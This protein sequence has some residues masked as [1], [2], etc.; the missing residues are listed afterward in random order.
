MA[1]T[2]F[3]DEPLWTN[4]H[5]TVR[6]VPVAGRFELHNSAGGAT[7]AHMVESAAAIQA[8]I[9]RACRERR[10][11]RAQGAAWSFSEAAAVPGGW[12]LATGHANWLFRLPASHVL[13]DYPFDRDGLIL[14]Q[15]GISVAELNMF[16]EVRGRS[17]ATTG[18]SNGQTFVGAMSTGTHG[19]AIDQPAIQGQV[20]AFQ[21]L[22]APDVNLWIEP[23]SQPVTDGRLAADLGAT[24]VRD[25]RLFSAALVGLG[26]FGIVHSVLVRTV[27]RF[28]MEMSRERRPLT[29][30][31]ERAMNGGGFDAADLPGGRRR[32][33]FFQ[34]VVNRHI[35]AGHAYVTV[36]YDLP[37][38]EDHQLDYDLVNKR[39]PGYELAVVVANLLSAFPGLTPPI[40]K[41]VLSD[42]LKSFKARKRSW[43]QSFNYT[44]PRS[45]TAGSSIAVPTE[46]TLEALEILQRAMK[47]TGKVPAAFACRYA[48]KSP[49]RLAFTRHE[50]TTI[51]DID[52]IDTVGTRKLMAQAVADLRAAGIPHAEHWGK[53][54]QMTAAS[55]RDSYRDDLEAWMRARTDLLDRQAEY[56]F[57]S[58]FLDRLGLTSPTF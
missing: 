58:A 47:R 8:L 18:A 1:K 25:D 54:N 36:G 29:E 23:A 24:L 3:F 12:C 56:V 39:G 9:G 43:G 21:L 52:G 53:I 15:T 40:T 27:P 34:S 26:A 6:D 19:S 50:R 30:G 41:A 48:T 7:L 51:V 20:A 42:Q 14:C 16:L 35:D 10:R 38:E 22:P 49:G 17:L 57:G 5:L 37:W 11:L 46:R 31:I 44:T 28:L 45:G 2:V 32:P 55:I 4:W 33:Y 13:L